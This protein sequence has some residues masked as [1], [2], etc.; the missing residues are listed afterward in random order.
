MPSTGSEENANQEIGVPGGDSC[1][2]DTSGTGAGETPAV[3][4]EALA[5]R[6]FCNGGEER[7][8]QGQGGLGVKH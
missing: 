8:P 2:R 7:D 6:R 1:V 5:V 3:R 4:G